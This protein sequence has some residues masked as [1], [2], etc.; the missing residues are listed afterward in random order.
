M[1][2]ESKKHN[3]SLTVSPALNRTALTRFD[4]WWA[5]LLPPV[6]KRVLPPWQISV[7]LVTLMAFYTS[8]QV[9]STMIVLFWASM[10]FT[11]LFRKLSRY[12]GHSRWIIPTYHAGL[13]FLVAQPVLAQVGASGDS[14][15]TS[16]L[17]SAVTNFVSQLFSAVSF[18]GVGGGT[19]S[20]L[21]CQVVGFL[22]I[23]LLLGFLGVIGYV[24]FQIGYQR[25]PISTVLDPLM[26]FLIFA[27]GA[28]VVIGV[29]V[30]TGTGGVTG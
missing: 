14:C 8:D 17:F 30:G 10:S 23:G 3:R 21:I 24:A 15:N 27:G 12:V 7:G 4:R 18:G 1:Y 26:A 22:T 13:S 11:W 29:M 25:Q 9:L 19:L 6:L 5:S 28:S 2:S 16:G 20:S